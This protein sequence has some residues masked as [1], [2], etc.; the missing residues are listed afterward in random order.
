MAVHSPQRKLT[1]EDFVRIPE[2]GRRHEILDGAHVV[3]PAPSRIHQ[4]IVVRLVTI[5][6]G[7]VEPRGLGEVYVAPFDVVLS[8][9]DVVEPDVLFLSASRAAILTDANVQGAPDLAVEILSPGTRRRDLGE[10]RARYELL[11]VLEYWIVDPKAASVLVFR[12]EGE[13]FLPPV[14][15]TA[16]A[17]DRLWTPLLP[18]LEISLR[19]VLKVKSFRAPGG[20]P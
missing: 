8:R 6:E 20:E 4:R 19:E 5:L 14:L 7:F 13:G 9:H 15:L 10:K 17:D 18:G 16:E 2:D 3:S 11:G 1:Y 12:R